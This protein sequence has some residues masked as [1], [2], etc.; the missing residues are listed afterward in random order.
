MVVDHQQNDCAYILLYERYTVEAVSSEPEPAPTTLPLVLGYPE[1]WDVL[2]AI[3]DFASSPA[4]PFRSADIAFG[5]VECVR[6]ICIP[7][8]APIMRSFLLSLHVVPLRVLSP[9]QRPAT[10]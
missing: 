3:V 8:I 6:D 9:F 4:L 5:A 10:L 1:F 7:E 2:S